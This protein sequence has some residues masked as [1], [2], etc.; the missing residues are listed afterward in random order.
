MSGGAPA[1]AA[2][3]PATSD[4][5]VVAECARVM[6]GAAR[7]YLLVDEVLRFCNPFTELFVDFAHLG[8]LWALDTRKCGRFAVS[9]R[10]TRPLSV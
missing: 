9:V 1:G 7:D 6:E 3:A 10:E 8:T 4:A 5:S 2:V